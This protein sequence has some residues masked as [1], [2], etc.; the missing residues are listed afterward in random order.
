[1]VAIKGIKTKH[2]LFKDLE[3]LVKVIAYIL[4]DFSKN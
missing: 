2:G 4:A 1:M 3:Q